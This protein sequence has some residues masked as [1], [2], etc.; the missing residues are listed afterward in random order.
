MDNLVECRRCGSNACYEQV[1]TPGEIQETVTTWLCMGCGFTTSTVMT[2][3]S[4]AVQAAIE[5]SPELYKALAHKDQKK[6]TW[7]PSTITIPGKGTVFVDGTDKDNWK[8]AA[9]K[10]VK[11]EESERSRFPEGQEFKMDMQSIQHFEQ[12][13]FMDALE[14]I[15]FYKVGE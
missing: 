12:K 8:W 2:E 7:F 14:L 15:D 1:I 13:N 5:S 9:I 3:G 11:I 10:A 4:P 6:L